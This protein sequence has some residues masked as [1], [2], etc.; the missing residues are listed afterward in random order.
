MNLFDDPKKRIE[1]LSENL[2]RHNYNYYVLDKPTVSDYEF[3]ALLQE[4]ILLEKAYPDYVL[5]NSPT[6]RV[7]GE[8]TKKFQSIEHRYPML[9]LGNTYSFEDLKEFD[10]RI[11]KLV[12]RDFSYIC[13]LK[14]D[15]VAIGLRYEN[16]LLTQAVTRGDGI[17]GDDV[18]TNVKTIQSIP[19][20]LIGD[21]FPADFEIRGEVM[22][23][24]KSFENLNKSRE[25][26]GEESFANPRNAASGSLKLQDSRETAK[27]KL[28]C[29]LYFLLG[30]E[31]N[32]KT[33]GERL[34][35]AQTMG[36]NT[37]H[38]YQK[39]AN[40][41]E[42]FEFIKIWDVKRKNLPFDIDGIVIKVNEI[43]LWETLGYTAK[44]PRW[45]IAY[46][47]KAERVATKLEAVSYQGGRTGSITPVATLTPVRLAGTTVKRASLHN[48]DIIERLDLHE[49]DTVWVEKGGEIIPKIV[50]VDVSKRDIFTN[51]IHFIT[52]C[53]ECQTLLVRN[54]GE[55]NHYCPNEDY[56]PPQIKG[57]LEHFISRKAMNLDSLGEGK[58]EMLYDSGLVK[59]AADLFNLTS[60]KLFGLEKTIVGDDGKSKIISFREK[61]VENILNA[62]EQAK[63]VPFER[64]LFALG[65]R[66]VGETVA[67]KLARHF[68]NI[69]NLSKATKEELLEVDEIGERIADS[70]LLYFSKQEHFELVEKLINKG[71]QLE[72]HEDL[73]NPKS[74]VLEGKIFVVSGVFSKPRDEIKILIEQHGGKHTSSISS[75]TSYLLAGD[76]M[77]PEKLKKAEKLNVSIISE[78]DFLTMIKSDV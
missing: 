20:K 16:G 60:D 71:L 75:Q 1:L 43:D 45:A 33:H 54:V 66:F 23:S 35:K 14:Y 74:T 57:R 26:D 18:T 68:K 48:A 76:K 6:Q 41:A 19:L 65:I 21:D 72:L 25:E 49:F 36:F 42:V 73:S 30:N 58:I 32:E 34:N 63:T 17:K 44:S 12:T 29:F 52:H 53:P 47:F 55:A 8:I 3:D 5:P 7:G 67:K 15:G 39:C 50:G 69:H 9:S 38:F 31:W 56:C 46:K 77:G 11:K 37:G 10:E 22:M 59:N 24:H 64:V 61:T 40:L 4:L 28:D 62:L 2:I 78:M 27:R 70:V 51:L 13:E